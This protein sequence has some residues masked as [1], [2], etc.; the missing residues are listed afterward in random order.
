MVKSNRLR[1][2]I[3]EDRVIRNAMRTPEN[4]QKA[5]K[6]GSRAVMEL[7]SKMEKYS[8]R[9]SNPNSDYLPKPKL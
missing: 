9:T 5:L 8:P 4:L 2:M 3:E 6:Y 1:D 7:F